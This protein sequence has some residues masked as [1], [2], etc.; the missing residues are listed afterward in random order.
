MNLVTK[1]RLRACLTIDKATLGD[2]LILPGNDNP[3]DTPSLGGARLLPG[4]VNSAQI[5]QWDEFAAFSWNMLDGASPTGPAG[6][7]AQMLASPLQH[8]IYRHSG[9]MDQITVSECQ[10]G[11]VETETTALFNVLN[12]RLSGHPYLCAPSPAPT[13]GGQEP[14]PYPAPPPSPAPVLRRMRMNPPMS[15]QQSCVAR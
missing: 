11:A 9:S 8:I 10:T 12:S 6:A 14:R 7:F 15:H 2:L 5:Y 3:Q 4:G 1:E 13:P